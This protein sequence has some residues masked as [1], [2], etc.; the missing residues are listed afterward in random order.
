[1]KAN[2]K[3]EIK[4]NLKKDSS[5]L[6][7]KETIKEAPKASKSDSEHSEDEAI[8]DSVIRPDLPDIMPKELEQELEAMK[9]N[10]GVIS[11]DT[12]AMPQQGNT[13]VDDMVAND[14]IIGHP[15]DTND[16]TYR[17][18]FSPLDFF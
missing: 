3:D 11:A 8:P 5:L 16:D 17:E 10:E 1:M 12:M 13:N 2:K 14:P 6:K 7:F 15:S 9:E 18:E 4:T